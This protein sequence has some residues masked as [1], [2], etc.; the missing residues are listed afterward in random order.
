MEPACLPAQPQGTSAV[1]RCPPLLLL[2][3]AVVFRNYWTFEDRDDGREKGSYTQ[4]SQG[5]LTRDVMGRASWCKT[6]TVLPLTIGLLNIE[7]D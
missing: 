4:R 1:K 6:Y 7:T 5:D 2:I 3:Q